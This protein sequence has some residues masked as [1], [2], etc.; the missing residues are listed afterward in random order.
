MSLTIPEEDH[1]SDDRSKRNSTVMSRPTVVNKRRKLTKKQPTSKKPTKKPAKDTALVIPPCGDGITFSIPGATV[2]ARHG[3]FPPFFADVLFA[4]LLKLDYNSD[5]SSAVT[6]FGK[7]VKIPRKQ[8]AFGDGKY[9]FA[10]VAVEGRGW[11]EQPLLKKAKEYVEK[12]MGVAFSYVLVN[13][14]SDG[15]DYIGWH[16]DDEVDM[17]TGAPIASV[18]LG[19]TRDFKLRHKITKTTYS[20]ELAHNSLLC[21][22]GACQQNYKHTLPKRLKVKQPRINLTWRVVTA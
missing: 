22:Q 15:K 21:M 6:L 5:E 7:K 18:S 16:A 2:F 13:K 14:Y 3:V 8:T 12:E 19:A 9:E 17:E 11:D 1:V 4:T 20:I 10:G